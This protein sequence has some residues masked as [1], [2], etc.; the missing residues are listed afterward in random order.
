MTGFNKDSPWSETDFRPIGD[1]YT[2]KGLLFGLKDKDGNILIN[3]QRNTSY[4]TLKD[5]A[6][7]LQCELVQVHGTWMFTPDREVGEINEDTGTMIL[8]MVFLALD[9][10]LVVWGYF[11]LQY[12]NVI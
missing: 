8:V 2:I 3:F 7:V 6:R 5:I 10:V 4:S 11:F 12:L 9:L 1:I